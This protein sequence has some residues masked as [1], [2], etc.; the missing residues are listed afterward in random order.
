MLIGL[1]DIAKNICFI[2]FDGIFSLKLIKLV[3]PFHQK[4]HH[5]NQSLI[6]HLYAA[7][8]QYKKLNRNILDY[9]ISF[10]FILL[11]LLK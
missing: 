9:T 7:K 2:S 4:R 8:C 11:L 5:F 1:G 6:S 3:F 10:Y